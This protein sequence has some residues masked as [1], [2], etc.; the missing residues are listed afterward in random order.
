MADQATRRSKRLAEKTPSKEG[1][2]SPP[3]RSQVSQGVKK[4]PQSQNDSPSRP[5]SRQQS[6]SGLSFVSTR[7]SLGDF[8]SPDTFAAKQRAGSR[9]S[10]D[11]LTRRQG[12][13]GRNSEDRA[14]LAARAQDVPSQDPRRRDVSM[15]PIF[16]GQSVDVAEQKLVSIQKAKDAYIRRPDLDPDQP[17]PSVESSTQTG[18]LS[19]PYQTVRDPIATF[20]PVPSHKTVWSNLLIENSR[21]NFNTSIIRRRP[22]GPWPEGYYHASGSLRDDRQVLDRFPWPAITY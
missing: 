13:F 1:L 16:E 4:Q 15:N 18:Q 14:F 6:V 3:K 9:D 2:K 21:Q 8:I 11:L 17:L 22:V 20:P 19:R 10:L 5:S 7:S 12:M